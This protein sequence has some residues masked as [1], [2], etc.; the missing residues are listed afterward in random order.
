MMGKFAILKNFMSIFA[1]FPN[2][3]C[4]LNYSELIARCCSK[5]SNLYYSH[6]ISR[7]KEI[8]HSFQLVSINP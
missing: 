2:N 6:E 5:G 1:I 3:I 4:A 8:S 7:V